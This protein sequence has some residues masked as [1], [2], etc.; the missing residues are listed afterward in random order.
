MKNGI[1]SNNMF[2]IINTKFIYINFI[3]T[4]CNIFL[5]FVIVFVAGELFEAPVEPASKAKIVSEK[6]SVERSQ[7]RLSNLELQQKFVELINPDNV[8]FKSGS[9]DLTEKGKEELKILAYSF[10]KPDFVGYGFSIEGHTDNIGKEDYNN[11]L[12]EDRAKAVYDCLI[13]NGIDQNRLKY[14]GFGKSQPIADNNTEKGRKINRRV[15]FKLF[16]TNHSEKVRN[17]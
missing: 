14:K 1:E 8:T 4:G 11:Q 13:R 17:E 10:N 12:S 5:F 16:K 3:I 2:N 6:S 7:T 9:S 15:E